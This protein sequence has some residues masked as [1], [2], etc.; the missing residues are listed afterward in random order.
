MEENES[1]DDSDVSRKRD[2]QRAVVVAGRD[3]GKGLVQERTCPRPAFPWARTAIV[4][5]GPLLPT[6]LVGASGTLVL[7]GTGIL[8]GSST[9]GASVTEVPLGCCCYNGGPDPR[10]RVESRVRLPFRHHWPIRQWKER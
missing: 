3:D 4:G 8:E 1:M 7:R 6:T 10:I 5:S 9:V 2:V